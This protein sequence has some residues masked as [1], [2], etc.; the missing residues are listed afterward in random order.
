MLQDYYVY[1]HKKKSDNSVFYVG[2]GRSTRANISFK[3][4]KAWKEA[5]KDGWYVEKLH[6]NL[7]NKEAIAIENALLKDND[8]NLANVAGVREQALISYEEV[9]KYL[10]YDENSPSG[11]SWVNT[12]NKR[13]VKKNGFAGYKDRVGYYS[14]RLNT[15]LYRAH[16]L[17]WVLF[18]KEIDE[19]MVINH[20]DHVRD[21]NKITNLELVT[22]AINARRTVVQKN[23]YAGIVYS[24]DTKKGAWIAYWY[25]LNSK[26]QG[27]SFNCKHYADAR[28][29]AYEYRQERLKEL[30]EKGAGYVLAGT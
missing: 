5:A 8:W 23:K 21:N 9:S 17:V 10:K 2:K 18:H 26:R 12:T 25:D 6:E 7:T 29:S 13:N 4:T 14:V 24:S 16:R 30:N 1:L 20:I 19:H 3:R 27:K 28:E 15:K 11:L 22:E